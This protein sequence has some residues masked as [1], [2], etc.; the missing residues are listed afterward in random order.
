[1]QFNK[2][3]Y[4]VVAEALEDEA[5]V[6]SALIADATRRLLA[7]SP[8]DSTLAHLQRRIGEIKGMERAMETLK[9]RAKEIR[10]G[11]DGE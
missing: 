9:K 3:D 2:P 6:L 8:E 7:T 5:G 11:E 4:V 1:M 10:G